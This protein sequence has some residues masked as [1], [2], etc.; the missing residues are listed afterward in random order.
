[1]P[2]DG[3]WMDADDAPGDPIGLAWVYCGRCGRDFQ[4]WLSCDRELCERCCSGI[5]ETEEE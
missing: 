1:M 4:T 5:E 2:E 3:E